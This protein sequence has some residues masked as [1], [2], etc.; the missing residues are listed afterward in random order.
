M[1]SSAGAAPAARSAPRVLARLRSITASPRFLVYLS[2][3]LITL[4]TAHW[5]GKEMQWDTLDYH[6]Y[7]GFSAIH[8]RFGRDYFAAAPQSYLNPYAYVPFYLLAISGLPAL[9]AAAILAALQSAILWLSYELAI[10]IMPPD[11]AHLRVAIGAS[12]ALLAFANPVLMQQLGSSFADIT[13]GEV[14]LAGWLIMIGAARASS[15]RR[16]VAAGLLLGA[17]SA[18]KL[19]NSLDALSVAIVPFFFPVIWPKR[20][21]FARLYGLSVGLAFVLVSAPW[22]FQLE[23]HFG[24]PLFPLLN[25]IF[26]SPEYTTAPVADLRFV[27]D[28]L[29]AVLWRPFAMTGSDRMVHFETPAPDLRYALLLVLAMLL[30]IVQLWCRSR[31][32]EVSAC[33]PHA[34]V[35]SRMLCALGCAFLINWMMWLSVSGNSRYFIPMACVAAVLIVSLS[36]RLF[37][38]HPRL[39]ACVIAAILGAQ[40]YQVQAGTAFRQPLPWERASWF[41]VSVP[42][43][44]GSQ[45]ALYLSVGIQSNSFIVPYLAVGSGIINIEGIYVLGPD[46]ANG[47]RIRELIGR[48]SPHL[49]VLVTDTRVSA[50]RDSD[51]PHLDD[52]NDA[53]APFGLR[54]DTTQCVRI[55]ARYAPKLQVVTTERQL[56][57]LP[58]SQ[59]YTRYIVSCRLVPDPV[60]EDAWVFKERAPNL[61]LDRIEDACPELLQPRRPVTFVRGNSVRGYTWLREYGNTNVLALVHDG[62]VIIRK[63]I[64]RERDRDVGS[65]F[66][67]ERGRL[68]VACGRHS[69]VR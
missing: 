35:E 63:L 53:V 6:F 40:I 68:P 32:R 28:S 66:A 11:R 23:R 50:D 59:W 29:A 34:P 2:C 31:H 9:G 25:G 17:A 49:R 16:M 60:R 27:P 33:E 19:T 39:L 12:A 21:Y 62:R 15:A 58:L 8:D 24:N 56:P 26:R 4:V 45:A 13:T 41:D 37:A 69:G 51:V 46:G 1:H 20:L 22:S 61:A 36:Y 7:A 55:V 5:M 57:R 10:A 14:A 44:L 54:V 43:A 64:G 38:A 67:W 52:V 65:E 47:A 42:Q 18:L 3:T 48:F 30:A